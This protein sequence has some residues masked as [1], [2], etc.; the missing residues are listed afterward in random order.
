MAKSI[1]ILDTIIENKIYHIRGQKVMLDKDLAEMYG[2]ETKQLKR[3]VKRNIDRFP[4][5]FMFEMNKEELQNWRS[6][7][8]TSNEDKMGLRYAP[9]CFTEQGVAMLSSVLNS[10][11]AI[12]VNI[13]IIRIFTKL[14]E[15]VSTHK[16]V[17]LKLEKLE[18]H[19]IVHGNY[20]KNH[21]SEIEAIFELIDELR[22]EREEEK[23]KEKARLSVPKNP[24]GFKTQTVKNNTPELKKE[25]R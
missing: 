7:I 1:L 14:R 10:K 22:K 2:V 21:D 19:L 17:L 24:I 3:Q 23:A 13:R 12:E 16:D 4:E 9:F 25:K 5:D 6:Q 18:K 11:N 8:G 20:I 15:V